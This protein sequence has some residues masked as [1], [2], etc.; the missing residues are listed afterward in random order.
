M[1]DL[2]RLYETALIFGALR[3]RAERE[4]MPQMNE[5][6][7]LI[8]QRLR[9][10]TF[11]S[12]ALRSTAEALHRLTDEWGSVID[13]MRGDRNVREAQAAFDRDD[14]AALRSLLPMIFA[15]L[16]PCE[17]TPPALY[18]AI[19]LAAPRRRP[20][21]RPFL[22]ATDAADRIAGFRRG[23]EPNSGGDWWDDRLRFL[24]LA[25]DFDALDAPV[26]LVFDL[27]GTNYTLFRVAEESA[28]RLYTPRLRAPFSVTL[29]GDPHDDWWE[30]AAEPY[31]AFRDRL[32]NTL[33]HHDIAVSITI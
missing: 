25:D 2:A 6:G 20:G 12:S 28:M 3:A 19:S 26:A 33:R 4:L 1:R 27:R 29:A 30:A 15:G 31:A 23:I 9:D 24:S 16:T 32:A 8:R 18:Y 14:Q 7:A 13:S 11:D 10:R 17:S 22:N 21:A 5:L